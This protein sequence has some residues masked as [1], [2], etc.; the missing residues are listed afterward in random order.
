MSMILQGLISGYRN[1]LD[2]ATRLVSDLTEEQ[3]VAQPAGLA[4]IAMNHP[5]WCLSHL[6]VYIPIIRQIIVGGE[7]VD[8]KDHRYGMQSKPEAERSGYPSKAAIVSEFTEGHERVMEELAQ[9][10]DAIFDYD[11]RLERWHTRMP[12]AGVALPYLMLLHENQHLGQISAW[13]R[14]MG[15]PKV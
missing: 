1:N 9:A 11:V 14:A 12:K 15:L 4:G 5:A 10:T 6:C 2:Y 7:I 8:P 3:M 13:R